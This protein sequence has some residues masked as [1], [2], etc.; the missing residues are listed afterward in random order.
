MDG[1]LTVRG[2]KMDKYLKNLETVQ[3]G[4]KINSRAGAVTTHQQ[5]TY[6]RLNVWYI[7]SRIANI[8]SM[9][10]LEQQYRITYNSYDGYYLV[11]TP[12]GVVQF[13]KDE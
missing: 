7:P 8:F 10:E 3:R 12:W 13:H 4:I 2:F 11:H 9:H 6:G 1:C 5:G